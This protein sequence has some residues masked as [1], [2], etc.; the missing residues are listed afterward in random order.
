M[1]LLPREAGGRSEPVSP[2]DG[3]YRPFVRHGERIVRAR[4]F[5]GPPRLAPGDGARVMVELEA[6][7]D[8]ASR[9]ADLDLLERDERLVGVMTILRICRSPLSV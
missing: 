7:L 6:D 3:S 8:S 2:R 5:E 1:L 4:V 9:G